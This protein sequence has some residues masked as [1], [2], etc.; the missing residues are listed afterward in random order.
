MK[1]TTIDRILAKIHTNVGGEELN[2]T[3]IITW[4]GEA[5]DFLKVV[6][7]REEVVT[8]LEVRNYTARLPRGLIAISQIAKDNHWQQGD[9]LVNLAEEVEEESD[10]E[11]C[12]SCKNGFVAVDCDGYPLDEN[13]ISYPGASYNFRHSY[14]NWVGSPFYKRRF[15]PVK[16]SNHTFFKMSVCKEK[17][18]NEMYIDVEDEYTIIGTIN[19]SLKFSFNEGAVALAYIRTP[20]DDETGYPLIPD[21]ISCLTAIEYYIKWKLAEK[22]VWSGREGF[23][24]LVQD[25]E[26]KWLKYIRQA[27]AELKMPQ[28]LDEYQNLLENTHQLLP[29]ENRYYNYFGNSY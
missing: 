1:F 22:M 10:T 21:E 23:V 7:A 9:D 14:L 24:G 20:I 27:K 2:E 11:D 5:L 3:D 29:R 13:D 17:D 28:S 6:K 25:S 16:L 26:Q 15:S 8:F 19:Q 4:A 18:F 12:E